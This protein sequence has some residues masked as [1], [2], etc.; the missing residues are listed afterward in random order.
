MTYMRT[1][2]V[3]QTQPLVGVLKSTPKLLLPSIGHSG[4][5]TSQLWSFGSSRGPSRFQAFFATWR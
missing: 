5:V 1:T 2:A 3:H 4:A